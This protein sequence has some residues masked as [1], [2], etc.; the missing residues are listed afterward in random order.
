MVGLGLVVACKKPPAEAPMLDAPAAGPEVAV[1]F[2]EDPEALGLGMRLYEAR[3]T[4]GEADAVPLAAALPLDPAAI[5]ALLAR[6]PPLEID[7]GDAV[8]FALRE[9]P[10]PP[11]RTGATVSL[12][13][14]GDTAAPIPVIESGPLTVLRRAPEGDVPMAPHLSVTFS[15]P[16]VAVTTQSEAR[17]TVPVKLTPTPKGEWRWLG[18]KTVVFEPDPRFPMATTYTVEIPAG[19]RG[20]DGDALAAPVTW[21]FSTPP[22]TLQAH[23]PVEEGRRRGVSGNPQP[24][25]PVIFLGFDQAV[26][27][28]V[29]VEKLKLRNGSVRSDGE[30]ALRIATAEEI[31]RSPEVEAAIGQAEPG[32]ALVVTPT[33]PLA[34]S[35]T[36]AV[37]VPA[38]SPSAEG[39]RLTTADQS[40][41]F[42]TYG[43]MLVSAP[44]CWNQRPCPPSA[45]WSLEF[46]NP[47][48][49]DR[50]D[51]SAITV[52]PAVPGL[53]V[54][55]DGRT[56]SVYGMFTGRTTY[57]VT[58]AAGIPDVFG[59]TL[60]EARTFTVDVGPAEQ[61]L[62]GP[63]DAF[64]TLD[65]AGPPALSFF[66]TNHKA[67][68]V[69][70]QRVE[71]GD[72]AK[73]THWLQ[74]Y[75]WED[76]RKGALPGKRVFGGRIAVASTPDRQVETTFDLTP[77]LT[78][79]TGQFIVQVEPTV[80]PKE[81]W[82]RQEWLAWVQVT[83]LGLTVFQDGSTLTVW[84]TDLADGKPRPDVSVAPLGEADPAVPSESA[85]TGT[86]GL[87]RVLLTSPVTGVV[88][89]TGDDTVILPAN[90]Q[91]YGGEW[92]PVEQ[93]DQL[94][95]FV[96]DDKN[97]YKPGET[98]H[99][100]GWLRVKTPGADGVL[101]R[102]RTSAVRW[103]AFSSQGNPM[104]EG[105]VKVSG[106]GGF[107][108]D[109]P[110]PTTPNLGTA[111]IELTA[112]N[113]EGDYAQTS[114]S[115]EI[116]EYR[117]PEFEVT[118]SG[119]DGVYA[120]GEDAIVD[121]SAAY[122]AGGGLP[123]APVSWEVSAAPASFVPP[124]RREWSFGVWSPWWRQ[125]G[126][127]DVPYVEPERLAGITDATGQHHLGI[128]FAS[129]RPTRPMTVTAQATVQDV[130]RQA[131]TAS[132]SFLVHPADVYVG[133]KTAKSYVEAGK[134]IEV[135]AILVDREGRT[136]VAGAAG[137]GSIAVALRRLVWKRTAKGWGEVAEEIGTTT[138]A[139][140]GK[141]QFVPD[142][143]GSYAIVASARD[144]HGRRNETELRVWVSGEQVVPD[145][146][147]AQDQVTLV[148]EKQAYA[149]GET[150]TVL[151]Q[152]PFW[153]AEGV[154]TVRAG[155]LLETRVFHM[156]GASTTLAIAVAERHVPDFTVA[157]D[158]VGARARAGDDGKPRT[159]LP[160]RVAYAGGSLTFDVPPVSRTLT[161]TVTPVLARLEPGGKTSVD[162][163]VTDPGGKPV[164]NA[165]LAVVAVDEAVLA[166]TGYALPDPLTVFYAARGDTV[167]AYHLRQWV[168]LVDPTS[169]PTTPTEGATG[170]GMRGFG[171]GG[172]GMAES[173]GAL[174]GMDEG[175]MLRSSTVARP[176]AAPPSE[177]MSMM[178][179]D[180]APDAANS[181]SSAPAI[182]V[183]SDFSAVA[184]WSPSVVTDAK[185]VA[186]VPLQVPDSLTRYRVMV[187]AVSGET[188]FG[189]G[190]A[191]V[192]AR[193][194]LM[195]RPSAPRFLNF[196]DRV[197]LPIVIQNQTDTALTVDLAVRSTN[198][199][200]LSSMADPLP[201]GSAAR[202]GQAGRRVTVPANDRVEVR[203]PAA[204]ARAGTARLQI[205]A[206][207]GT[208]ADAADV[209]LPV[210]TPATTEAFATYGTSDAASFDA[211]AERLTVAAP[212]DVWPQFGGL[213]V[214]VSSTQ[215][216]A[217]TDAFVYLVKYP[218]DCNEQIASR[219]LGVAALRDVLG[220]FESKE[221]PPA[222]VLQ[223]TV[224]ADIERLARRQN[225]DGGWAFWRRGDDGW[226]YLGVHVTHAL[227]RAKAK[228]YTVEPTSYDRALGYTRTIESHLPRWYSREAKWAIRA[229]ALNVLS[230]AGQPS[231]AKAKAL[232]A[233]AG[234]DQ[235]GVE[236]LGWLLPTLVEGKATKEVAAIR[237]WL[238]NHVTESAAGA[239]FVT[240]YSD[241]AQV[242][243]HSDRVADGVLL[244]A[245][246]RT[247]PKS[248]L[249][250][251]LVNGLL[252]HRTAG[253]WSNTTENAH[254]LLALDRYFHVYEGV[255]PAF[256]ARV[257]LGSGVAGERPFEGRSTERAQ[258]DVPMAWLQDNGA[259]DLVVGKEGKGRLYYRVGLRYA[260][261]DLDADAADYGFAVERRYE[262]I[263]DPA[264]VTRAADG[265][266]TFR[267]GARVR[268]RLTMATPMRRYHVALVDPLPAG[269]EVLNPDLAVTGALPQD[270][271]AEK[272]PYW[273]WARTWY[274][275]ENL[276]DERVEAF[277]SLLWDGVHTY[278][279][280]ARATTPGEF[281]VPPTKA[282]EMY[283][284]ETFGR[285]SGDRVIVR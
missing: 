24:L 277:A 99:V 92:H 148:P 202:G 284:P 122:Y 144:S 111:R 194:P 88:A 188:S 44:T 251:K 203:F 9:G 226:P 7:P 16:M 41:A 59:Q 132:K 177:P 262:A 158:L 91:G 123:S 275:H 175:R 119:A 98:V 110:I 259:Q 50:F 105:S 36:Y 223:A 83:K 78:G 120:L 126:G 57:T 271:S 279:Y 102:S 12:P 54:N 253:R 26:E 131:W 222:D 190:E 157:V 15:R 21:T 267:A 79:K 31:A 210:W 28:A 77:Y 29:L 142:A 112:E 76:V 23:L 107:T 272:S 8:D 66:S 138:I 1:E 104:G 257:W 69:S 200:L 139:G 232:V 208:Y 247:E 14:P 211:G 283:S 263:D 192:T 261:L 230:L 243:L 250:P 205:A 161:V 147:V 233:E 191:D 94:R 156:D 95:W 143:G 285:G 87:A 141:A 37:V 75:R 2:Q 18:T 244:E 124:G 173:A 20:T 280:V 169:L 67:L 225:P 227:V 90:P 140:A 183:R 195:V 278:T 136:V 10:Q 61:S 155:G 89:R 113:G 196:G 40:F 86:D 60:A 214:T 152:A 160:K 133:L 239:H 130:N 47:L 84:A 184:L 174:G 258:V 149:V 82:Q 236:S 231:V 213:E 39:P 168:R 129:L 49:L 97:L 6:L 103:S 248:D 27:P 252:A 62:T 197:E 281:V 186:R 19:T 115:F 137:E 17:K 176:A 35:T 216:Q 71:T 235:L 118:A 127:D 204:A 11:P 38:G 234:V 51:P 215:L 228:G 134:P 96:F 163:L 260:P 185:G 273:W 229:Y 63:G 135:E 55:A 270:P 212:P 46:T 153:P 74:N 22:L 58:V 198:L 274:D 81:R 30:I 256:L 265:T 5:T 207:S 170:L 242:L 56:V 172:G 42:Q 150:A 224:A 193:L 217:L 241:G 106:L 249:V 276:R 52:T 151:V 128:H 268:V 189:S 43:P 64:V 109:L 145:R 266:W 181:G 159:D 162:L 199:S 80:Q 238:G 180:F 68:E 146:G 206:V 264:D 116:Q 165:E 125:W 121:V 237:G 34:R 93:L 182:Q 245:L 219:L 220:A 48:D 164:A 65:P 25:D 108:F 179:K 218:Y 171:G 255:T 167:G 178:D 246:L 154:L 187:V 3:P 117:T 85:R 13:F 254:I 240:S 70:V 33:V 100:R 101:A 32:R 53:Q 269:L 114:L 72:W 45:P 4:D 166:L 282:E 73:W 209:E 201:M 221:L